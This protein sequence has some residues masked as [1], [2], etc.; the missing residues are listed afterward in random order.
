MTKNNDASR[1][2]INSRTTILLNLR[3]ISHIQLLRYLSNIHG[4]KTKQNLKIHTIYIHATERKTL[5][6]YYTVF[7]RFANFCLT[8]AVATRW[9]GKHIPSIHFASKQVC[10]SLKCSEIETSLCTSLIGTVSGVDCV[11]VSRPHD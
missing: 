7:L 3:H 10:G 8:A 4:A 6:E 9:H 2:I 1:K 5:N 11:A